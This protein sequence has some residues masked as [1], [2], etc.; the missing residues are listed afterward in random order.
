MKKVSL[1]NRKLVSL[2]SIVLVTLLTVG[3]ATAL[4]FLKPKDYVTIESGQFVVGKITDKGEF[5]KS[6]DYL[7]TNDLIACDDLSVTPIY[8]AKSQYQIFFYDS[9]YEFVYRT[10]I[11]SG[12]FEFVE[13]IP[14][15]EYC[16]IMILPDRQ[17]KSA[18]EFKITIFN[19]SKYLNEFEIS[20]NKVQVIGAYRDY[21]EADTSLVNKKIHPSWS[22]GTITYLDIENLG[23]SK[24]VDLTGVDCFY[25]LTDTKISKGD[26]L[27][28]CLLADSNDYLQFYENSQDVYTY[29]GSY[30]YYKVDCKEYSSVIFNYVLGS[31]CHL[32]LDKG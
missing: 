7:C 2:I 32:Y 16:R 11:L 23:V 31:D 24:V 14:F 26:S 4:I 22:D 1:K 21:F 29:A 10:N 9:N 25:F 18:D 27:F 30:Y 19:K 15:V 28:L 5:M 20:V 17:D 12:K 8:N 13:S 6:D 3:I